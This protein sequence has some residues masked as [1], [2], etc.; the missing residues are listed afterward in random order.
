MYQI[1]KRVNSL[2][3]PE[4]EH[5]GVNEMLKKFQT[6][7]GE[8]QGMKELF[9]SLL[10]NSIKEIPL[11]NKEIP[12]EISELQA[13]NKRLLLEISELQT[14]ISAE[15]NSN[16]I[17]L[18]ENQRIVTID[19]NLQNEIDDFNLDF[20]ASKL[21]PTLEETIESLLQE[22]RTEPEIIEKEITK[23]VKAPLKE[24]EILIEL[25]DDECLIVDA[26]AENRAKKL[27]NEPV[28]RAEMVHQLALTKST[29]FN[30]SGEFYTG[31]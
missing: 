18:Q 30:W 25:S 17:E 12:L 28:T 5:A 10:S 22:V 31:L 14:K 6:K 9:F 21:E 15:N 20:M 3:I 11:E 19:E 16:S 23:E 7:F 24:N 27:K 1:T 2:T 4:H 29:V 26:I 8:S 13:E